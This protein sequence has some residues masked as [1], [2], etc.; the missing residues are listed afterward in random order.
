MSDLPASLYKYRAIK[1]P[2]KLCEDNAIKALLGSY[3]I[4]SGRRNFNDPF[5]SK[6]DFIAPTAAEL[7][8]IRNNAPKAVSN[9]IEGY[10][11]RGR[12]TE[13]G[14][15]YIKNLVTD[16]NRI[17]D[18]YGFY[19]ATPDPTSNLMWSHYADSHYGFCIEFNAESLNPEK[20]TYQKS[21]PSIKISEVLTPHFTNKDPD[22]ISKKIWRALRIKLDEW[23]YENEYRCQLRDPRLESIIRSGQNWAKAQY[24]LDNIK[25][26]IFGFRMPEEIKQYI[27]SNMPYKVPYKQAVVRT[28]NI[29]IVEYKKP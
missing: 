18:G 7:K 4:F 20:V 1:D 5:D 23:S 6:I 21:I 12:L 13:N 15:D 9:T 25:S 28:S 10:Y 22:E 24:T 2:K 17:V 16:F 3:A 29:G 14:K 8:Q 26:V 11:N 27:I 19:C